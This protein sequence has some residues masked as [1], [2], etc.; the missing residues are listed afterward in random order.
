MPACSTP[1]R[2]FRSLSPQSHPERVFESRSHAA[3]RL[4]V[5]RQATTLR[6]RNAE[7]LSLTRFLTSEASGRGCASGARN[8]D[9]VRGQNS[10]SNIAPSTDSPGA[11][12]R[13]PKHRMSLSV[14]YAAWSIPVL[15]NP[16]PASLS[17]RL[18]NLLLVA[19]GC[20]LFSCHCFIKDAQ[21]A[22]QGGITGFVLTVRGLD[23]WQPRP[24]RSL[25]LR[26]KR[27][28]RNAQPLRRKRLR[29]RRAPPRRGRGNPPRKRRL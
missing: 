2:V 7:A 28:L 9:E 26:R 27:R 4:R 17:R 18:K 6:S 16:M 8:D 14:H 13:L 12:R 15:L 19:S 23:N 10:Q 22:A 29:G 1:P 5:G 11:W 21:F 20:S 25:L 3:D 24:R